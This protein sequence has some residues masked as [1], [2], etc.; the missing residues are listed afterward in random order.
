MGL[1]GHH[2]I[3]N[4]LKKYPSSAREFFGYSNETEGTGRDRQAGGT[5]SR[6]GVEC[7][8]LIKNTGY[9]IGQEKIK[10]KT[11]DG[12]KKKSPHLDG[13]DQHG[14]TGEA[15]NI[16]DSPHFSAIPELLITPRG[17]R[18]D[19]ISP[20]PPPY[21]AARPVSRSSFPPFRVIPQRSTVPG[22]RVSR[23]R[24]QRTNRPRPPQ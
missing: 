19:G 3:D 7:R 23:Q 17:Y 11:V 12:K 24:N 10:K 16:T 4:V 20:P 9:R 15:G 13:C 6:I 21:R 1:N 8:C 2:T 18:V 22:R 14:D 5:G